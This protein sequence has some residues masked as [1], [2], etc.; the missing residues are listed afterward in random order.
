MLLRKH[1][2]M[3]SSFFA[4]LR[5]A[6]SVIQVLIILFF[7]SVDDEVVIKIIKER[8]DECESKGKSWI[9]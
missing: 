3:V 7:T 1:I 8:V 6:P 2:T 9:V 5:T 4:H